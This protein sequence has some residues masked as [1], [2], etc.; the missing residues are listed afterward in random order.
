VD[1]SGRPEIL[2]GRMRA[3][4]GCCA[5]PVGCSEGQSWLREASR[6]WGDEVGGWLVFEVVGA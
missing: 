5:E 1:V 6:W 2:R 3:A 4:T